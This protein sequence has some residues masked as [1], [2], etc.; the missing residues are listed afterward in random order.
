MGNLINIVVSLSAIIVCLFKN[1]KPLS[2]ILWC[3]FVNFVHKI[4][5]NIAILLKDLSSSG[6][7]LHKNRQSYLF[8]C[9]YCDKVLISQSH[10]SLWELK[11]RVSSQ[12]GTRGARGTVDDYPL[13]PGFQRGLI[14]VEYS[15][16]Y[17]F[18]RCKHMIKLF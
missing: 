8:F 9:K 3:Y 17:I 5:S 6:R 18:F 10:M 7:N 4:Y 11:S 14:F 15:H 16:S 12:M 1:V 2:S 13:K